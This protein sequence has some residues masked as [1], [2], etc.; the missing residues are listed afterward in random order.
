MRELTEVQKENIRNIVRVENFSYYHSKDFYVNNFHEDEVSIL[1]Y[2]GETSNYYYYYADDNWILFHNGE[3]VT[4]PKYKILSYVGLYNLYVTDYFSIDVTLYSETKVL[5]NSLREDFKKVLS[6]LI[7][8]ECLGQTCGKGFDDI[9]YVTPVG[10]LFAI[11]IT[12][13]GNKLELEFVNNTVNASWTAYFNKDKDGQW[14][15]SCWG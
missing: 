5:S 15:F 9:S 8:L 1:P 3:P 2:F 14:Y 12:D 13:S 7:S 4:N 10:H 6:N 11:S